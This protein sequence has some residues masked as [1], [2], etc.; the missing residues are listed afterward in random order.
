MSVPYN[1]INGSWW[2]DG[3]LDKALSTDNGNP[4]RHKK[5]WGLLHA[6][7]TEQTYRSQATQVYLKL[8][9][10]SNAQ[11]LPGSYSLAQTK[12]GKIRLNICKALVSTACARVSKTKTRVLALT[13]GGDQSQAMRAKKLTKLIAGLFEMTGTYKKMQAGF[14]DAASLDLGAMHVF[15]DPDT[16]QPQSERVFPGELRFDDMEAA[17]ELPRSIH[18]VKVMARSVVKARYP[19]LADEIDKAPNISELNTYS[20]MRPDLIEVCESHHVKSGKAA[21]DGRH[22][23][24]CETCTLVDEVWNKTYLP[25]VFLY[26]ERALLGMWGQGI[27]STIAPL[28]L[29]INEL[30]ATI[31]KSLRLAAP[32]VLVEKGSEVNDA[33]VTGNDLFRLISYVG[34]PP[35][36]VV[37]NAVHPQLVQQLDSLIQQ[38]W[39]LSGISR[40]A[41]HGEKP[42]GIESGV[43]LR[44]YDDIETER[45]AIVAQDYE[46]AHI[47]VAKLLLD[48]CRDLSEQGVDVHVN[49]IDKRRAD[50]LD[51]SKVKLDEDDYVLQLFP[52]SLLPNTPSGRLATVEDMMKIGL[53]DQVQGLRLLDYPDLDSF[54]MLANSAL[55]NLYARLDKLIDPENPTYV[56]PEPYHNLQL[57]L[58]IATQYYERAQLDGIAEESLDYLR[59]YMDD[60]M[61]LMAAAQPPPAPA[62]VPGQPPMPVPAQPG[63]PQG[64][65]EISLA[66]GSVL[67]TV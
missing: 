67:P 65:P 31:T 7:N 38:C 46:Q 19:E 14:R 55:D 36:V 11:A 39:D 48:L 24:T 50:K 9:S 17:T 15:Q 29:E 59:Q 30:L 37:P 53:I 3:Q 12:K 6:L 35:T 54:N 43:A 33:E 60:C 23:I 22:S 5:V 21:E 20:G 58:Q 41:S 62:Q 51:W 40:T 8:V 25:Y 2:E 45:F 47:E 63:T 1:V 27:V 16:E 26:W 49:T 64:V 61:R 18:R 4:E 10:G 66:Q 34:Q 28:Q 13:T 57:S 32:F 42:A 56:P 52:T 44:T